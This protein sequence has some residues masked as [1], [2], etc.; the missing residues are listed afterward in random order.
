MRQNAVR[1]AR[2]QARKSQLKTQV[3]KLLDLVHDRKLKEVDG[4]L[5]ET[6]QVIDT[7]AAKG[8]IHR[9]AANRKKS[10]LAK[11]VNK[12]KATGTGT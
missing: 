10:R 12:L 5:R 1:R 6:V 7:I 8:T 9:N 4:A 11:K 2:N 3:R